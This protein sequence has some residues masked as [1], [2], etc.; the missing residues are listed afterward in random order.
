VRE[1]YARRL[2]ETPELAQIFR[3]VGRE[4]EIEGLI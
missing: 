4:A 1:Q 3:E 2:A